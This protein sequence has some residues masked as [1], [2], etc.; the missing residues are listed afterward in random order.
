MGLEKHYRDNNG[1]L[2]K[3]WHITNA[4]MAPRTLL[5]RENMSADHSESESGE[6]H[7]EYKL[8]V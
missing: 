8:N 4:S 2:S 3:K 7:Y 6:L 1:A 5:C